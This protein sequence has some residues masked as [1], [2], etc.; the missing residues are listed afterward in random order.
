MAPMRPPSAASIRSGETAPPGPPKPYAIRPIWA[1][2]LP[3]ERS[4]NTRGIS[5]MSRPAEVKPRRKS[6]S[7]GRSSDADVAAVVAG[8]HEDPFGVLG[9]HEVDRHWIARTFIAGADRVTAEIG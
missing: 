2:S 3:T 8:A 1:G 6:S 9:L 7:R 4:G 5:G